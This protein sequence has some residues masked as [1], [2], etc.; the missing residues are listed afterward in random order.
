MRWVAPLAAIATVGFRC[1]HSQVPERKTYVISED[2]SGVG[3]DVGSGTGGSGA[4]AYCNEIQK[5]C[6]MACW[7]RKPSVSSIKKGSGMHHEHCTKTCREEF[8][9]CIEAQAELEKQDSRKTELHFPTVVAALEWLREHKAEVAVGTIVIV[10]GVIAAPYV[11]A[12][13]AGGALVLAPL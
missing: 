13:A 7:T 8:T 5:Q 12:I 10:A 2:A 6:F 1:A 11:V 3:S 9:R 4:E